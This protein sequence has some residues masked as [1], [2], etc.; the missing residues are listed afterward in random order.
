MKL[1]FTTPNNLD[2]LDMLRHFRYRLRIGRQGRLCTSVSSP[3]GGWFGW[4]R[5]DRRN[6]KVTFLP[7]GGGGSQG[8]GGIRRGGKIHCCKVTD[9]GQMAFSERDERVRPRF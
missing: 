8:G 1:P 2:F 4:L 3:F 6:V 7:W 5:L 9:D